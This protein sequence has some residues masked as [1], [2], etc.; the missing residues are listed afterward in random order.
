MITTSIDDRRRLIRSLEEAP[1]EL[2]EAIAEILGTST[3]RSAES[4]F[5]IRALK[6]LIKLSKS[7]RLVE[8]AA[9]SSDYSL[10]LKALSSPEAME[11][12]AATDPLAKAEVRGILVKQQL[13]EASGGTY[14]SK[15]VADL[16]GISRQAVDKRRKNSKLIGI[17]KGKGS[18][19]YPVWQFTSGKTIVGLELVMNVIKDLDP[20]MQVTFML[21]PTLN[22]NKKNPIALLEEG[23]IDKAVEIAKIYLNDE[24]E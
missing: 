23:S 12:L 7:D 2:K 15:E 19:L 17:P 18:Y 14:N 21:N 11:L 22:E 16:L 9:A 3:S 10:L 6:A 1:I 5:F 4:I 20:W 13:I 8:T 24:I